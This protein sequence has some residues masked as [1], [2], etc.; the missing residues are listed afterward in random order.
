V[1]RKDFSVLPARASNPRTI[2]RGSA[3][4]ATVWIVIA[5]AVLAVGTGAIL[6]MVPE[7]VRRV[8]I[9]RIAETTGEPV[10]IADVDFNPFTG[11][12]RARQVR[13]GDPGAPLFTVDG[14]EGRLRLMP[15]LSGRVRVD[16]ATF[17]R[18]V[19]R[20]SRIA[21]GALNIS[22][23]I[24]RWRQQPPRETPLDAAIGRLAILDG[25][26]TFEDRV[27]QPI[28]RWSAEHL[29]IELRNL[30][31]APDAGAGSGLLTFAIAGGRVSVAA[32]TF[33]VAPFATEAVVR[34][35]A[36]PLSSFGPYL[37]PNPEVTP[38]RGILDAALTVQYDE[39]GG[40]RGDGWTV[41]RDLVLRRAGQK[42]PFVTVP[43]LTVSAT[44]L[45]FVG[46]A[47]GAARVSVSAIPTVV[48]GSVSPAARFEFTS[49][50]LLMRDVRWPGGG[51]S[52]VELTGA[53]ADGAS[54]NGRGTLDLGT[55]SGNL[56]VVLANVALGRFNAYVPSDAPLTL[57][58]GV[59]HATLQTRHA[60]AA[61]VQ[62]S[63][64]G[65]VRGLTVA[66]RDLGD[67][68][69]I[70]TLAFIA[71]DAALRNG[72]ITVA[73]VEL[74]GDPTITDATVAPGQQ[75][76]RQQSRVV[77]EGL[78]WPPG[79]PARIEATTRVATGGSVTVQGTVTPW[80]L[81]ADVTVTATDLDLRPFRQYLPSDWPVQIER[82]T[83]STRAAL[84]YSA[85]TARVEGT[86][87]VR[88]LT[89]LRKDR[90]EPF[91]RARAIDLEVAALEIA[92]GRV[93]A[94][95]IVATGGATITDASVTPPSRIALRD[96]R[97][98]VE[99]LSWPQG[100]PRPGAAA[101]LSP[102][103]LA[104]AARARAPHRARRPPVLGR[105]HPGGWH[106][107]RAAPDCPPKG[108]PRAAREGE[109]HRPRGGRAR[110]RGR[111]RERAPDRRHRR[112]HDDGCLGNAAI[113]HR[114]A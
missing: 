96:S 34:V 95:R 78:R 102:G 70:P 37:P 18:P 61:E 35:E 97:V 36:V 82:A 54:V 5:V 80:P 10:A 24:E 71:A 94:G 53:L 30:G 17:S 47:L 77:V 108:S 2:L 7:G 15:L 69:S 76:A 41:L 59:L 73:R 19:V 98:V 62:I 48:A 33:D 51:A 57:R 103:E 92:D 64:Q 91:A 93:S 56:E 12:F 111:S 25:T 99:A 100:P 9:A 105:D 23:V 22:A 8:A 46:A 3:G 52:P 83:L 107:Q 38:T 32:R 40:L 50:S 60:G 86:A 39:P 85:G 16:E 42:E 89:V 66:R 79:P 74:A 1:P 75:V 114:P 109:G 87:S 44:D 4:R 28:R 58:G 104:G 55:L 113:T 6:L 65:T 43:A 112:G 21:P 81:D 31:T 106:G 110:D 45:R 49:T 13:V 11:K 101:R 67:I 63:G 68:V 26:V 72:V 29:S 88:R 14:M 84:R 27:L 90:S 20:I